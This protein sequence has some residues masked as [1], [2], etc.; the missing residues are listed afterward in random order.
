MYRFLFWISISVFSVGAFAQNETDA[1]QP[2]LNEFG[3][4]ARALGLGGAYAPVAEDYTAVYWNPAGLAQIRKMEFFG[5]LS[6]ISNNNAISY[7]GTRT[8]TSNGFTGINAVGFVFPV[9]TTRG[10]LVFGIGYHRVNAFDDYNKV[11]GSA[12]FGSASFDQSERTTVSGSLN[13]WSFA[14]AVDLTRNVSVGATLNIVAGKNELNVSYF[15]DDRPHDVIDSV[16]T[17]DVS[18]AVKPNYSGVNLK[19][20]TLLRPAKNL[21]LAMTVTTPTYLEVEENSN[22]SDYAEYDGG[23]IIPDF[24]VKYLKYKIRS[25]WKY[26]FGASYKYKLAL[27]TGSIE[28]VDWQQTHFSSDIIDDV[29][30]ENIDESINAAF[31][32][33]YRTTTNFRLGAETVVP[34]L[35]CKLMGGY[36][37]RP[38]PYKNGIEAVNSDKSFLSA[39]VSFLLDE[40][41]K[42]DAAYQYGWWNQSTTDNQLGADENGISYRTSEKITSKKILISLSYRF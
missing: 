14:G 32:D 4:G 27:L 28:W 11:V 3:P 23:T 22:Y 39:G 5:A 10:S 24:D 9:P 20:G 7:Y 16:Y 2:F 15:E 38:S 34:Q 6:H 12:P 19:L 18:F 8:E 37:Y 1:V 36:A 13:H 42:I 35:G 33:K 40:Q 30:G 41:V 17:R 21:R 29:T 26:E 25:P 31:L